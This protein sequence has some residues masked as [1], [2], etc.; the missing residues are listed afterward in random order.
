MPDVLNLDACTDCVQKGDT[1]RQ[2]YQSLVSWRDANTL[3]GAINTRNNRVVTFDTGERQGS[4]C[5][6]RGAVG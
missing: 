3:P 5:E 2:G 4:A 1:G 6:V